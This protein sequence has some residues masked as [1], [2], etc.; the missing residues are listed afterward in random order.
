MKE[1]DGSLCC[2][3]GNGELT[4]SLTLQSQ[5]LR[6]LPLFTTPCPSCGLQ[7]SCRA[8][9]NILPSLSQWTASNYLSTPATL[10]STYRFA[11]FKQQDS[12]HHPCFWPSSMSCSKNPSA[13]ISSVLP[14]VM[15]TGALCD[16]LCA[17]SC[18]M[19]TSR[20]RTTTNNSGFS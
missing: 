9:S 17:K 8:L 19:H 20:A 1:N 3:C 13:F 11:T 15:L 7:T 4:Q 12:N 2:L 14:Y 6:P 5:N 16:R 10:N 18:D